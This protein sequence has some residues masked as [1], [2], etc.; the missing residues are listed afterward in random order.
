MNES[1]EPTI[2]SESTEV[3]RV[4]VVARWNSWVQVFDPASG[5]VQWVNLEGAAFA[6]A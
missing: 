1:Q 5:H 2:E 4:Q 6:P 3:R